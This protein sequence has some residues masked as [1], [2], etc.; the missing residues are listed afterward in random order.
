[1]NKKIIVGIAIAAVLVLSIGVIDSLK[2]TL[3][4]ESVEL[5]GEEGMEKTLNI[6]ESNEQ[7]ESAADE[8]REYGGE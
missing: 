6:Q 3:G 1:M 7:G 5:P 2:T 8:A 4:D